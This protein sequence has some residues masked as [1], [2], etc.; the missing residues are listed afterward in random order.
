MILNSRQLF[1][2]VR[3]NVNQY[4]FTYIFTASMLQLFLMFGGVWLLSELFDLVLLAARQAN[5]DQHNFLVVMTNPWSMVAIIAYFVGLAFLMFLE[6]SV[7]TLMI[8]AKQVDTHF[9]WRTILKHA[10]IRLKKMRLIDFVSFVLYL[11]L[12]IP[13]AGAGLASTLTERLYIPD[14]IVGEFIKTPVG[15]VGVILSALV[16]I[17]LN[18]RLFFTFPLVSITEDSFSQS[19]KRSWQ[20]SKSRMFRW[21]GAILIY[22]AWLFILNIAIILVVVIAVYFVDPMDNNFIVQA[23]ALMVMKSVIFFFA[24]LTKIGVI[25][26]AVIVIMEERQDSHTL[27]HHQRE[28]KFKSKWVP[29]FVTGFVMGTFAWNAWRLYIWEV[30]PKQEI[31]AH[32]G[33]IGAGVEN[34]IEALKAA[35]DQGADSVEVDIQ[36]TKDHQFVVMHDYN[37]KRL[38]KVNRE[39]KDM[40]ADEII[41]LPIQQAGFTST[42]PSFET[43]VQ[44]AKDLN[45]KLF[46]ELKPHGAE[47][48]NYAELFIN[49][50]RELNV[51]EQY[52]VMS[53]DLKLMEAINQQA[54]E[55]TVGYVIPIQFGSFAN[56]NVDFFV[57]EDFSYRNF[58]VEQARQQQKDVY[59]W[60]INDESKITKYLDRPISGI[61]T[62]VPDMVKALRHDMSTETNYSDKLMRLLDMGS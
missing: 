23:V 17:Y 20:M 59:V 47:P 9:S 32:R 1:R 53:L 12:T 26:T 10:F 30:N 56:N 37:L 44:V 16:L 14:F 3:R 33:Y 25:T 34:S 45:V 8:Y 57:I 42:V 48:N 51:A 6:F 11:I 40:T 4:K 28:T 19:V 58:L 29:L 54:P 49:K 36:L 15:L 27:K 21:M 35:V 2:Q 22:E 38:A 60:T 39:V 24:A 5:V 61:I 7:L 46:V 52:R 13:L 43:F 18:I 55:M 62:D 50:M 41:G 31:I